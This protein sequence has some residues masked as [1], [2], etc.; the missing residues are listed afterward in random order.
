[1]EAELKRR[2]QNLEKNML[3]KED[4]FGYLYRE[5]RKEIR[6]LIEKKD[7][8][9]EGT[10]NYREK[11]WTESL[12]MINK[13]LIKMY[14]AQGEFEGTMNSIGQRQ[15]EMIKQLALTMEWSVLNRSGEGSKLRQPQVQIPDFSPSAVGYKLDVVN[16][17]SSHRNER[18]RK[19]LTLLFLLFSLSVPN[20]HS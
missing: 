20:V 15:S 6:A 19:Y 13:N 14:S 16:L 18:K 8:E 5:H 4:A 9:L 10:L 11:C 12:D 2:D 7:K 17:P 3:Q 1:M